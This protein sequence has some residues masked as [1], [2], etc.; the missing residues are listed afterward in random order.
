VGQ[1]GVTSAW[2]QEQLWKDHM[3][4]TT[5]CI[6]YVY[7]GFSHKG[8]EEHCWLELDDIVIDLTAD[9][10][11][12]GLHVVCEESEALRRRLIDYNSVTRFFVLPSEDAD[13]RRRLALIYKALS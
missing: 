13:L 9:Q 8:S 3:L 12:V 10:L 5:Y 11:D 1:C 6:G 2:L 7:T 4:V